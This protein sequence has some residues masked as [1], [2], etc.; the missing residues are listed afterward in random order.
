MQQLRNANGTMHSEGATH[1]IWGEIQLGTHW[2]QIELP[3]AM[4]A[5]GD[6]FLEIDWRKA[7][8][9]FSRHPWLYS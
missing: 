6:I 2:E 8:V 5:K 4:I 1:Y 7:E 9:K 3:I